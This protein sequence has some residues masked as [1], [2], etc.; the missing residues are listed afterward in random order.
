[1]RFMHMSTPFSRGRTFAIVVGFAAVTLAGCRGNAMNK[2]AQGHTKEEALVSAANAGDLDAVNGF[3]AAGVDV[4]AR[5]AR[6]STA[7]MDASAG[8]HLNVVQ[9]LLA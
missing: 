5:N 9:A 8:G 2:Y 6:G 7:L 4:N 1:M 3:L